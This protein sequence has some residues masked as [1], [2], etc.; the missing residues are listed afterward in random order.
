M[1]S[2]IPIVAILSSEPWLPYALVA[3]TAICVL[4]PVWLIYQF[5][6]SGR[7]I[8]RLHAQDAAAL[9]QFRQITWRMETRIAS[10]EG[11]LDTEAPGWRHKSEFRG[12]YHGTMG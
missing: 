9:A 10:L 12:E 4:G 11:I 7:R 1:T 6:I 8:G 3:C 5:A 2:L